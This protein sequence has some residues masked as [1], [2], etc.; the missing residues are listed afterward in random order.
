M[1]QYSQKYMAVVV[2]K[3]QYLACLFIIS[4]YN[5][6]YWYLNKILEDV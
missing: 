2:V 1:D 6:Y 4:A 3:W 5:A